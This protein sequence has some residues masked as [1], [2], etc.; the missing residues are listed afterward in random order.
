MKNNGIKNHDSRDQMGLQDGSNRC[1]QK[2]YF[3]L[4]TTLLLDYQ[5]MS[6]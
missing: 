2:R 4:L 6:T 3:K 5:L 1:L